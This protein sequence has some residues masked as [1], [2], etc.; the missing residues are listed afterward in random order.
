MSDRKFISYS[1]DQDSLLPPSLRDWL[2]EG[3]LAHFVSDSVD[4]FDL[5]EWEA[6][7]VSKTGAGAPPFPPQMM[8]KVM[9]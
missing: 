7:Y 5:S 3:H 6:S 1:Q 9:L 4:S 2:P 8:L